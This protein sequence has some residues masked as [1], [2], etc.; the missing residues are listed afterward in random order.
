M[1]TSGF[2]FARRCYWRQKHIAVLTHQPSHFVQYRI[3]VLAPRCL[4]ILHRPSL[5]PDHDLDLDLD[6]DHDLD[7][8]L[9]HD[10]D[11][12]LDIDHDPDFDHDL[13]LDHDHDLDIDPDHD[14]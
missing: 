14:Q 5:D 2:P 1:G 11:H 8:N 7:L 10:P 6:I 3:L 9:D 13:D 4:H 12:D